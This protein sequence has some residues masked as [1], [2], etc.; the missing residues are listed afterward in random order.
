MPYLDDTASCTTSKLQ[1]KEASLARDCFPAS[2][3]PNQQSIS[4][5]F[6]MILA[7]LHT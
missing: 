2:A 7:I 1:M 6:A 5:G 4:L 3:N